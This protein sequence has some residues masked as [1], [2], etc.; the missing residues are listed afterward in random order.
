LAAKTTVSKLERNI[1][2]AFS[3]SGGSPPT[4]TSI[5]SPTPEA[6]PASANP[7]SLLLNLAEASPVIGLTVWQL[8][9]VIASGELPVVR[10]GKKIYVRRAALTRWVERAE[11]K[12]RTQRIARRKK[13][14][15]A[16]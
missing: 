11:G 12:H 14:A 7:N 16:S 6:N 2:N 9:G 13:E 4:A 8:R 10:V 1:S 5:P 15:V 3:V